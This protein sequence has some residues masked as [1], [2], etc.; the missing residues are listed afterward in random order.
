MDKT[1]LYYCARCGS[2]YPQR[3]D[4]ED[5][6]GSSCEYCKLPKIKVSFWD[7]DKRKKKIAL[8]E[9]L[10]K[11]RRLI[12]SDFY[13][14]DLETPDKIADP[15]DAWRIQLSVH[16]FFWDNYVDVPENDKLDREWFEKNKA[17]M[18]EY[19]NRGGACAEIS[20]RNKAASQPIRCPKC[21]SPSVSAQSKFNTSKAV[22]GAVIAG[23]AGA[24]I[25][26]KG[27]NGVVNVCQN[28]GHKWE[29]GK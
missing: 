6:K 12:K 3:F 15:M 28:C 20:A 5:L 1:R 10:R 7:F 17:H 9:K 29:P 26:G 11:D 8:L 25:G 24:V 23:A 4:D 27:G 16:Q 22:A 18:M 13:L 14:E 2:I 21:G 19:F